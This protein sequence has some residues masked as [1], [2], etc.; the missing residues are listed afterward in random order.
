MGWG[1]VVT[2]SCTDVYS[3]LTARLEL[4]CFIFDS[5]RLIPSDCG[6]AEN[7]KPS[8]G[9]SCEWCGV[10]RVALSRLQIL[11]FN[12]FLTFDTTVGGF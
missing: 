12:C 6:V 8:E 3:C 5:L 10:V 4:P 7:H 2:A 11:G 9:A 1:C